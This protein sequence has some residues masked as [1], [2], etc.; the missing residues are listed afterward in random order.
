[1][2]EVF[3]GR[4]NLAKLI[5]R[6]AKEKRV[7]VPVTFDIMNNEETPDYE[8]VGDAVPE[9]MHLMG[10]APAHAPKSFLFYPREVVAKYPSSDAEAAVE[11]PPTVVIGPRGCDVRGA[12]EVRQ[13]LLEHRA[14]H[15]GVRRPVLH[16]EAEEHLHRLP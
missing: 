14:L 1:M 10:A 4:E 16:R 13:G 12:F 15:R 8:L 6:W 7:Y 11:A 5:G 9:N 2:R 3:I